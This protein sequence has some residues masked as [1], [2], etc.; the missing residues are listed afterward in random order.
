MT[1]F[2]IINITNTNVYFNA[3]TLEKNIHHSFAATFI[4][5]FLTENS[6]NFLTEFTPEM[7]LSSSYRQKRH[8]INSPFSKIKDRLRVKN[9]NYQTPKSI[10]F[11]Y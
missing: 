9:K 4:P 10:Y 11:F 8:D 6:A 7:R 1:K 5:A 2:N 3:L